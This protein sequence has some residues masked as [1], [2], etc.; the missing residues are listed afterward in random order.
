MPDDPLPL[1]LQ[2]VVGALIFTLPLSLLCRFVTKR[3]Q[4]VK[5]RI[6]DLVILFAIVGAYWAA[7]LAMSGVPEIVRS[8][9][10]FW[11]G[12]SW[13]SWMSIYLPFGATMTLFEWLEIRKRRESNQPVEPTPV[14]APR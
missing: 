2:S 12:L 1:W 3:I 7:S 13:S 11:F 6:A 4:G 14:S 5:A 9:F 10:M 8:P